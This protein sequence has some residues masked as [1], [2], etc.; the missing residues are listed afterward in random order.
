ME[1]KINS[2]NQK[3]VSAIPEGMRSVTPYL[4]VQGAKELIRFIE[5]S[6]NGKT[7]GLMNTTDGKVMHSLVQIGDSQ[8]M[9]TDATDRY[10]AGKS[11][12]YIYVEDCDATYEKAIEAEAS[13]LREPTDEFYGDRSCGVKDKWGNEWWIATH[14]EDVD[15]DE[16]EKRAKKFSERVEA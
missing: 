14:I 6:F 3:A 10:P 15:N 4:M 1:K 5:K 8:L 7:L 12:L 16:I 9:I 13:S 2:K 11:R